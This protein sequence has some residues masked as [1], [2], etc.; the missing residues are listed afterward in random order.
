MDREEALGLAAQAW[1]TDK[2]SGKVMDTDL[3]E[4]FAD[5]LL[6]HIDTLKR[7]SVSELVKQVNNQHER[8]VSIVTANEE[9][10]RNYM[11][12]VNNGD[13]IMAE[14]KTAIEKCVELNKANEELRRENEGLKKGFCVTVVE[15]NEQPKAGAD[16]IEKLMVW[17]RN[18]YSID[19]ACGGLH[20]NTPLLKEAAE[21][22]ADLKK[23]LTEA[24]ADKA[25]ACQSLG[26]CGDCWATSSL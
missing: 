10:R 6:S 19:M 5:I 24:K 7:E 4:A 22:I 20:E 25:N 1:C 26:E 13:K 12:A 21:Q 18:R 17:Y 11:D 16:L 15:A 2:T 9:L 3:V 14:L 23:K 8:F